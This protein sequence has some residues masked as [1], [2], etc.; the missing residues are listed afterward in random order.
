MTNS[1]TAVWFLVSLH[2]AVADRAWPGKCALAGNG[3]FGSPVM[4]AESLSSRSSRLS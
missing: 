3:P 4:P 2:R 1:R